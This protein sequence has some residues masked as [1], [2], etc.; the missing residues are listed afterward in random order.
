MARIA[1]IVCPGK[2]H[3]ITQRGNRR[4]QTFFNDDDYQSYQTLM[5]DWCKEYGVK[6]WAYC[7]M[8][9]HIHLI[10]IP[11]TKE[12]LKSAIGE[13]HRRYTRMINFRKGWRGHLWQGRFSSF[14][15]DENYL[16][17]CT[18]YIEM[19]PVRASLVKKAEDWP[20]SSA[21]AHI[22]GKNDMLV[23]VNP[24]LRLI[25]KEWGDFYQNIRMKLTSNY[26]ENTNEPAARWE[27][28]FSLIILN[29][30]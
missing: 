30:F 29:P 15:L 2:P 25:K 26:Y 28:K 21:S 8:P 3:H 6:I 10:A 23:N 11:K 27:R 14:I 9:N 16:L 20:W 4:Q 7:L 13:A 18:R 24:L 19:N 12:S 17:A 22:K 5:S 1:R